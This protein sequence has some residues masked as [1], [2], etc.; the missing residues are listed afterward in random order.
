MNNQEDEDQP[1]HIKESPKWQEFVRILERDERD[2]DRRMLK[3]GTSVIFHPARPDAFREDNSAN[4]QRFMRL[5]WTWTKETRQHAWFPQLISMREE[6]IDSAEQCRSAKNAFLSAID[7]NIAG[8]VGQPIPEVKSLPFWFSLLTW[9]PK[10]KEVVE[11]ADLTN[12]LVTD[13]IKQS[14]VPEQVHCPDEWWDWLVSLNK[15][16]VYTLS[17]LSTTVH[18]VAS[19]VT[20]VRFHPT[21][22]PEQ[23]LPGQDVVDGI[24]SI[25]SRWANG[26]GTARTSFTFLT[27]GS[28]SS[29]REQVS[30]YAANDHWLIVSNQES[31][32]SWGTQTPP[33][34]A[35]RLSLHNFMDRLRP[36]T[37]QQRISKIKHFVDELLDAGYEGNIHLEKIKEST[38]YRRTAVRDALLA[39]QDS[40]HY[41][42]YKT[43]QGLIAVGSKSANTGTTLTA[44][45]F[46]SSWLTRL[47]CLG[48]AVSV[49]IWFAKD[50]ILGRSFEVWSFVV[51]LPLAYAGEWLN[52]RF[53]KWHK[54]KE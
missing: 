8:A 40:G 45:S 42:L 54:D 4:R 10:I 50:V 14:R 44:S 23:E 46:Q 13:I 12:Q 19:F 25:Y 48:P 16:K 26:E 18:V 1:V 52:T 29:W 7:E 47:A 15:L 11:I 33:R 35:D 9:E 24:Q 28:A 30:G 27:I 39:L 20:I 31:N 43:S 5:D 41:R 34:F 2:I 51:L 6:L 37:R 32:G 17:G 3:A 53:K 22:H 21:G 38:G 49:G 36:E